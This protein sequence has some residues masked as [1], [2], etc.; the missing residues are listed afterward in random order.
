MK[1]QT[2]LNI[3]GVT[4]LIIGLAVFMPTVYFMH[5]N[6]VNAAS[7]KTFIPVSSVIKL[8][9][10]ITGKPQTLSIPSL[11]INLPVIDGVYNSTSGEWNLS[12]NKAHFA[13]ITTPPNDQAG[14][15]LIYGHY[16]PEVF[17]YL[18]HIK[19]GAEA[20]I[21]TDNGLRFTYIYKSSIAVEPTDTSIFTYQGPPK[22]TIQTC[23][24]SFMQNRQMY[25]FDF[26]R[27]E[28]L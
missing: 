6:R 12:L 8:V 25:S 2:K 17:A 27:V 23:S 22:L 16:R 5:K 18:H 26:V 7:P 13:L 20:M 15:T 11:K 19:P 9:T 21:E 28:K 1:L 4:F 10:A 24:G 3:I 14:N